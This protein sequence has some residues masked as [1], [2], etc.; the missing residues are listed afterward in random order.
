MENLKTRR[1]YPHPHMLV[2]RSWGMSCW[3]LPHSTAPRLISTHG[4]LALA[5]L[6]GKP[7]IRQRRQVLELSNFAL[8]HLY[9]RA[10]AMF[11]MTDLAVITTRSYCD[12]SSLRTSLPPV[13]DGFFRWMEF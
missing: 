1:F 10:D 2:T 7:Q 3:L 6:C 13:D 9:G 12:G 8:R 11:S 4:M 5:I